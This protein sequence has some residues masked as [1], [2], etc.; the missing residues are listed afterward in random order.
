MAAKP[1]QKYFRGRFQCRLNDK[2][3][4]S[5]PSAFR[6]KS[7][8]SETLIVTNSLYQGNK[9]L[10][11][12]SL[13]Q[14]TELEK[15]IL[16]LPRLKPEVQAYQRFYM[17]GGLEVKIDSQSRMLIPMSLRQFANLK[18]DVMIVGLGNKFEVWSEK[19]WSRLYENMNNNFDQIVET[20]SELMNEK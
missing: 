1:K 9:C 17:A 16:K 7:E 18:E 5:L 10:D 15:Q 3:R 6:G 11:V 2:G 20:V 13:K 12:Y 14:W 4:L 19:V 8:S